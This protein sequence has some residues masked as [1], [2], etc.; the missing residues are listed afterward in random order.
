M[1]GLAELNSPLHLCHAK[2]KGP[3]KEAFFSTHILLATIRWKAQDRKPITVAKAEL[4]TIITQQVESYLPDASHFVVQV[5]LKPIGGRTKLQILLDA[6][7]GL[8]IETCARVSRQL[9]AWFE[10]TDLIKE[11]FILEVSSP[12]LDFPLEGLRMFAKNTG[13]ILKVLTA[14]GQTL[15]GKLLQ[16]DAESITLAPILKK[17]LKKG[18]EPPANWVLPYTTVKKALVQVEFGPDND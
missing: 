17:K 3:R 11:A 16:A 5:A 8:E 10:E 12:G 18:E 15:K 2:R 9:G 6:D 14:D 4:T 1:P 7:N 13:R